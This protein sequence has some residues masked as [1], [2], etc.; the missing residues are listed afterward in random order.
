MEFEKALNCFNQ[1]PFFKNFTK[2]ER[3][4]LAS[5]DCNLIIFS[6]GESIIR[7]GET[8]RSLYILLEGSVA[9]TLDK[10]PETTITYLKPGSIFGEVSLISKRK[11]STNVVSSGSSSVLKM[12]GEMINRLN[13]G[14]VSKVKDQVIDLLIQR[15]DAMN[16][17]FVD[18]LG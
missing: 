18:K 15:L 8:D 14:L 1:V 6:P 3:R 2:E 4:F 17:R 9:V 5:L 12:D 11:R 10:S 16:E 7:Q 13:P